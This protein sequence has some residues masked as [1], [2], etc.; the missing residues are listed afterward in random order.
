MDSPRS[1]G[2][3]PSGFPPQVFARPITEI[4]FLLEAGLSPCLERM[5]LPGQSH[6]AFRF[7]GSWNFL[8]RAHRYKVKSE[9]NVRIRGSR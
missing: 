8:F 5:R 1:A 4:L 7:Y 2:V 9:S 3:P 6:P